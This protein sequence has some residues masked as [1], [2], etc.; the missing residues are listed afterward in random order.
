VR[1]AELPN[2]E[3]N[4]GPGQAYVARDAVTDGDGRFVFANLPAG[5]YNLYVDAVNGFVRLAWPQEAAV[6]EGRTADVTI[7][8]QRTGAIEGRIQDDHGDGLLNAPVYAIR[9]RAVSGHVA[10]GPTVRTTT[11]DLGAF[12]LSNLPAGE[13]YVLAAPR[14]DNRPP[15]ND[16]LKEPA[17]QTG[18]A[19]TYYPGVPRIEGARVVQVRSGRDSERVNFTTARC[20]LATL[21]I[22]AVDSTG[23]PLGRDGHLALT[24]RDD[25]HLSDSVN[26]SFRR[27]NGTFRFE[28]IQPGDYDLVVNTS[29]KIEEAAYVHVSIDGTDLSVRVQT[30]A[31]AKVSG[32]IIVD[33]L[34]GDRAVRD[35]SVSSNPPFGTYGV[36]YAHVPLFHGQR[37]ERFELTGLRGSMELGADVGGGALVSIR[38]HGEELAGQTL[39]FVG[40]E[41]FDDVV[42][43]LTTQVA[44]VDVTVTAPRAR[45]EPTSAL[46]FLFPE[47]P[48]RWHPGFVRYSRARV[49]Q[50]ARVNAQMIRLPVGRYL[51]AAVPD[52]DGGSYP[53]D[54]GK[55][56][57]LRTLE[58]LRPLATPVTLVA[59]ET[60]KV[61]VAVAR[62]RKD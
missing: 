55:L 41:T 39:E 44:Q 47:D 19:N 48:Q 23:A 15:V 12:R 45:K 62:K 34:P 50:D 52:E 40:T 32:R 46:V 9:K 18:F 42:V 31:G 25:V 20:R 24:R 26:Q 6:T 2:S 30:N 1:L 58:T 37:T 51:V 22:D 21:A 14:Y 61:T 35:V 29:Y 43:E 38:R 17:P 10:L 16:G 49:G 59:G 53:T 11:N 56:E 27:E 8:M 57:R 60:A 36:S 54:V 28:G 4:A 3:P 13:Y 7:R 33:G 5:S